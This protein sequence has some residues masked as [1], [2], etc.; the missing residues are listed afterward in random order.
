MYLE[1]GIIA[2]F[3]AMLCW[4]VGDFFIQRTTRKIGDIGAIAFMSLIGALGLLPFVLGDIHFLF[5]LNNLA[6]LLLLS[7]AAVVAALLNFEALKRGKLSVVDVVL[8]AELPVTVFLGFLFFSETLS[9]MQAIFIG[10]IVLGVALIAAGTDL[11]RFMKNSEKGIVLAFIAAIAMGFVNF[12]TAAGSRQMS[13]VLIIWAPWLVAAVV[14]FAF[15]LK[16]DG[17]SKTV[18]KALKY[19]KLLIAMGIFETA[20]W[21]LFA[22]AVLENP[23]SITVAISQSYPA[24]AL[25]FGVL[26]NREKIVR[27]QYLGAA[28]VL[29]SSFM[30]GIIV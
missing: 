7:L 20:A 19:R 22:V 15:L 24:I 14:A 18:K 1:I 5:Q 30:L 4:G 11:R 17:A 9:A 21:L 3:G 25:M 28:I 10:L 16:T 26:V 23:L 12:L 2:A 27:H 6:L 8:Q 29:I 13:P